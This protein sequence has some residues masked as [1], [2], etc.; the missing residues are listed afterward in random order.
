MSHAITLRCTRCGARKPPEALVPHGLCSRCEDT[1]DIKAG[2]TA[3]V[4]LGG[5]LLAGLAL[6]LSR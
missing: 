5:M 2:L 3:A 1:L 6:V 4:I